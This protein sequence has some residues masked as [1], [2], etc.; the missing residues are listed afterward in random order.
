MPLSV[1]L[2]SYNTFYPLQKYNIIFEK[3]KDTGT[4]FPLFNNCHCSGILVLLVFVVGELHHIHVHILLSKLTAM[5]GFSI[6]M[7]VEVI[8]EED[9]VA[10]AVVDLHLE[11][12]DEVAFSEELIIHPVTVW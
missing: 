9:Q 7:L 8:G 4:T 10:P 12:F 11:L 1:V 3:A 2:C 6:P 5:I